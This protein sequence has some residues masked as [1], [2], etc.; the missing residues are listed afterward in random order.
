[1]RVSAFQ[2]HPELVRFIT[3]RIEGAFPLNLMEYNVMAIVKLF[4]LN[5]ILLMF[6]RRMTCLKIREYLS[7]S[8]FNPFSLAE[9]HLESGSGVYRRILQSRCARLCF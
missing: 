9:R 8:P 1:M 4:S 7:F 6:V 5:G 2:K 3:A